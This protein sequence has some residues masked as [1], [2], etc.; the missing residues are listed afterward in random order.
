[1]AFKLKDEDS[2]SNYVPPIKVYSGTSGALGKYVD[3]K[4]VA[5]EVAAAK[6]K[7]SAQKMAY[8]AAQAAAAKADSASVNDAK[9]RVLASWLAS[10]GKVPNGAPLGSTAANAP[11]PKT[12]GGGGG[13]GGSAPSGSVV[14]GAAPTTAK[15]NKLYTA[16]ELADMFGFTFGQ[17]EIESILN[18]ATNA[19][20]NEMD[21]QTA[22]LRD[23]ALTDY[24]GAYK[25]YN[26]QNRQNRSRAMKNGLSRGSNIAQEVLSQVQAQQGGAFNQQ[27]YQQQLGELTNMRGSQ[28]AMDKMNAMN[29]QNGLAGSIGTMAVNQYSNNVQEDAAYM[30]YLGQMAQAE[31]QKAVAGATRDSASIY[32]GA[33][34]NATNAGTNDTNAYIQSMIDAGYLK[35][36]AMGVGYGTVPYAEA[37]A[38]K[39]AREKSLLPKKTYNPALIKFG[40]LANR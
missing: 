28:L 10:Q 40:N 24:S 23:R 32:A 6:A 8:E 5:A 20:F 21:S 7:I 25:Q 18:Q 29:T 3:P 35:E 19:K 36:E 16:Q 2:G 17:D 9:A 4:A 14:S 27:Q 26:D 22:Q 1:M 37:K 38:A 12:G 11:A 34:N 15:R 13:G 31:A 30:A 39:L 33:Q